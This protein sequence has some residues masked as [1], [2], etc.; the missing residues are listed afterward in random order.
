MIRPN[1]YHGLKKQ[2]LRTTYLA[3][4]QQSLKQYR[5]V[6]LPT[7]GLDKPMLRLMGFD[8][9]SGAAGSLG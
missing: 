8:L 7:Y 3:C 9:L 2:G 4:P 6:G 1:K 5:F